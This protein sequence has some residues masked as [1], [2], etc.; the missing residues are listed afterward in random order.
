MIDSMASARSTGAS[1]DANISLEQAMARIA[2]LENE[3][4]TTRETVLGSEG[5]M[6]LLFNLRASELDLT[7]LMDTQSISG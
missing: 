3:M 2:D 1:G 7:E 6:G 5:L 4:S